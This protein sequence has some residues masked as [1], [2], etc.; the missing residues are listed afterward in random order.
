MQLQSC[1]ECTNT[2]N[3]RYF[4]CPP[5][6]SDGRHFT[7]YRTNCHLNSK[8]VLDSYDNKSA[9]SSHDYRQYLIKNGEKLMDINRENVFKE[10]KCGT[11]DNN[12]MLP[13]QTNIMCD[14]Q[15]CKVV[16]NAK[17][18]LGQGRQYESSK[19]NV[20]MG[21]NKQKE[22]SVKKPI[23]SCCSTKF[24]D[25]QFYPMDGVIEEGY[26]RYASP[27]GGIPLSGTSRTNFF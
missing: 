1:D 15:K 17:H 23:T 22:M 12:T 11:C 19:F 8:H 25:L 4:D 10:N 24:D 18:G 27:G 20:K 7:D 21:E 3:N 9:F 2:T 13:P 5:R 26:G 6:M 16:L 14:D